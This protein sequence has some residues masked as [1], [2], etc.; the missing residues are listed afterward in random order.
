MR[1]SVV[2]L[3]FVSHRLLGVLLLEPFSA[4]GGCLQVEFHVAS[5]LEGIAGGETRARIAHILIRLD[6]AELE[7]RNATY[8]DSIAAM[9]THMI[10]L[11]YLQTVT[12]ETTSE[13]E[14]G[15]L[16][17]SLRLLQNNGK[18]RRRT[19]E[20]AQI[21]ADNRGEVGGNAGAESVL[22]PLWCSDDYTDYHRDRW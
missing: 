19:C 16:A 15:K 21:I 6:E 9:Q 14:S 10:V 13:D 20:A 3:L 22:S 18:L 2:H 8:T 17:A 1:L 11:P 4:S 7:R 12:L 5:G